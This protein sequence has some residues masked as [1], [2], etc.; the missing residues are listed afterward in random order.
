MSEL[1]PDDDYRKT[2]TMASFLLSLYDAAPAAPPAPH[3]VFTAGGEAVPIARVAPLALAH[4]EQL[5]E[6]LNAAVWSLFPV[7]A[8]V[9]ELG[10]LRA[11]AEA[12]CA[13][14][15]PPRRAEE[16]HQSTADHPLP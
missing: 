7:D 11:Q 9:D 15:V 14:W 5:D 12:E 10:E 6:S 13:R 2:T 3:C 1:E 8:S 4:Y 16:H